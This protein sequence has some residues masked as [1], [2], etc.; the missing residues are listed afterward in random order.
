[1]HII[2]THY[3]P[4]AH[5]TVSMKC[6]RCGC[7]INA[8]VGRIH[9]YTRRYN[10]WGRW[11]IWPGEECSKFRY[12]LLHAKNRPMQQLM[13]CIYMSWHR[14]NWFGDVHCC[15]GSHNLYI[16]KCAYTY[17]GWFPNVLRDTTQCTTSVRKKKNNWSKKTKYR[18]HKFNNKKQSVQ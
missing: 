11:S 2:Y 3:M 16:L 4:D 17:Y 6:H 8:V 15:A 1:M 14:S 12:S 5:Y 13:A 18:N 7:S 9:N 10:Y